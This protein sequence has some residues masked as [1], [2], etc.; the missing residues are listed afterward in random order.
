M[1]CISC[2]LI[3]DY[4]YSLYSKLSVIQISELEQA[5]AR[6]SEI[7]AV[8]IN[9]NLLTVTL[10]IYQLATITKLDYTASSIECIVIL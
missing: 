6:M 1:S 9:Y 3:H 8:N 10:I 7:G 2:F 4:L 5:T